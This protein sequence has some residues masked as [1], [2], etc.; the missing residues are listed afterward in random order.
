MSDNFDP[1]DMDFDIEEIEQVIA[2]AAQIGGIDN[3]SGG[4]PSD[5]DGGIGGGD[6]DFAAR[7][8][9]RMCETW[10]WPFC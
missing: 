7:P 5:I 9:R 8:T 10:C 6:E 1:K 2:P 4:D 3:I